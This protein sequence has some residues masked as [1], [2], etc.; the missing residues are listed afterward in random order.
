MTGLINVN[1]NFN[2]TT[3]S[4]TAPPNNLKKWNQ[5]KVI[6]S[7]FF[8]RYV[9]IQNGEKER[10]VPSLELNP[11]KLQTFRNGICDGN[12]IRLELPFKDIQKLPKEKQGEQAVKHV[13]CWLKILRL[14]LPPNPKTTGA[15][16]VD[17]TNLNNNNTRNSIEA[18]FPL[19]QENE[20]YFIECD[21]WSAF[22]D[23]SP[24]DLEDDIFHLNEYLKIRQLTPLSSLN[25]MVDEDPISVDIS[26]IVR[27]ENRNDLLKKYPLMKK[28]NGKWKLPCI[29]KRYLSYQDIHIEPTLPSI[30]PWGIVENL[31]PELNGMCI[32]GLDIPE[33]N[34]FRFYTSPFLN[35]VI[36][37][38]QFL[39]RINEFAASCLQVLAYGHLEERNAALFILRHIGEHVTHLSLGG[40][41]LNVRLCLIPTLQD[42][43][44]HLKSLRLKYYMVRNDEM[45][46]IQSFSH[47]ESLEFSDSDIMSGLTFDGLPKSLT[48]LHF[49]GTVIRDNVLLGLKSFPNLKELRLNNTS[50]TGATFSELPPS[51]EKLDCSYSTQLQDQGVA[52]LKS[53]V[54]LEELDLACTSITGATFSA[55][56]P[57]LKRLNCDLCEKL[58]DQGVARLQSCVLLEELNLSYTSIT[59]ATFSA[60]PPSLKKLKCENCRQLR[61]PGIAGLKSCVRLE[62]LHFFGASIAG[63]TFSELPPSLKILGCNCC[64]NLTSKAIEGLRF[65]T[66]LE[67]LEISDAILQAPNFSL[68]S[69]LLKEFRCAGCYSLQDSDLTSLQNFNNLEKLDV[70]HTRLTGATF[71]FFPHS[72]KELTFEECAK[73]TEQVF[74]GIH[75]LTNLEVLN[76]RYNKVSGK[77]FSLLPV[78]L[79]KLDV[80]GSEAIGDDAVESLA[81]CI[82][83]QEANFYNTR[84]TD[85]SLPKLPKSIKILEWPFSP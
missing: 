53:C 49:N 43:F 82:H 42:L 23:I 78:S 37:R 50:I 79:R 2:N 74:D 71:S 83:L 57:S 58:Q 13:K 35:Q 18:T 21:H 9:F 15:V 45:K 56:P 73:L 72:L 3:S 11:Y 12:S 65:C 46:V 40:T 75:L 84:V 70:S 17:V 76:F 31:P 8:E 77:K 47:L 61:D 85:A 25:S 26:A 81:H 19:Y 34:D 28:E 59:G 38:G 41:R 20:R 69:P 14:V 67:K 24:W 29:K 16:R 4:Q 27:E 22:R 5:E 30:N 1:T 48:R 36:A 39:D 32:N 55:I 54:L 10:L 60:L 51:L 6:D 33:L 7:S 63:T 66:K 80:K 62:E 52:E 64:N 44:P 68:L